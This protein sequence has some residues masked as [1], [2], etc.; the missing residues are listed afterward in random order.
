MHEFLNK[1][2]ESHL[3]IPIGMVDL[4]EDKKIAYS[5]Q[6]NAQTF[7]KT[8][9]YDKANG[10]DREYEIIVYSNYFPSTAD[11]IAGMDDAAF[12]DRKEFYNK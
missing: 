5:N 3:I 12:Y 9:R 11:Q 7:A 10:I 1:D 8:S 4:D 2:G 6:V